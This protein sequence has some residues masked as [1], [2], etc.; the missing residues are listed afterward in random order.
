[1]RLAKTLPYLALAFLLAGCATTNEQTR[2]N[3]Y[4]FNYDNLS[5]QII[6]INTSTGEGTNFLSLINEEGTEVLNARDL[7]QDGM[8]DVILKGSLSLEQANSIYVAG[9]I[10]ARLTGH[11]K[12]QN[13]LR[14]FEFIEDD[15][16]YIVR[17]YFI[18]E[19]AL[20]NMF[21]IHDETGVPASILED[22]NADGTLDHIEK[23][24]I[25][26]EKAQPIY[27]DVLKKG[28]LKGRIEF[29]NNTYIIQE[30]MNPVSAGLNIVYSSDN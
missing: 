20:H 1:M 9:I 15:I 19:S 4:T 17:S 3:V 18:D 10:N 27:T 23:G 22:L 21:I 29:I 12:E 28:V 24:S 14:S 16:L 25:S 13:P 30:R 8:L 26:L 7:D 11:Y 5:Y 2:K 6:S